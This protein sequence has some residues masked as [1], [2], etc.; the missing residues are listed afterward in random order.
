MQ[1]GQTLR[2][3]L[4]HPQL[5]GVQRQAEAG[6]KLLSVAAEKRAHAPASQVSDPRWAVHQSLKLCF[7]YYFFASLNRGLYLLKDVKLRVFEI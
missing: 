4:L 6:R 1:A 2:L 3:A 5:Q 7:F